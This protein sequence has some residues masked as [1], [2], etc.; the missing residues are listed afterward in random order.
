MTYFTEGYIFS[1]MKPDFMEQ[2][3]VTVVNSWIRFVLKCKQYRIRLWCDV[4]SF[5]ITIMTDW[6]WHLCQIRM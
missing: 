3:H 6:Q 2:A 1:R 4:L 5:S